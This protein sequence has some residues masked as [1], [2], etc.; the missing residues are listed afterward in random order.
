VDQ[1]VRTPVNTTVDRRGVLLFASLGLVL[2]ILDL[3]LKWVLFTPEATRLHD[4]I[5]FDETMGR[6]LVIGSERRE[7]RVIPYVLNLRLTVNE[8]AVFGLG[9]GK[10]AVFAGVSVIAS[11]ILL[12]M[13]RNSGKSRVEQLIL[14]MLLA[15]VLGNFYDRIK[16]N[17]VR[18]MFYA[19]P[20]Q[21]WESWFPFIQ[22][23]WSNH[24]IFPWI[25]NL[26]D[27]YLVCGV[28]LLLIR[29][30]ILSRRETKALVPSAA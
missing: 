22:T 1:S 3:G 15:G 20:G 24:E 10:Q 13:L 8:G 19:F 26:A 21:T 18:D 25:F 4:G 9:Q 27:A 5:I 12:W 2:L 11:G 6:T 17:Y 16:Y 23:S 29:S 30:V 7:I 28:A 14:G